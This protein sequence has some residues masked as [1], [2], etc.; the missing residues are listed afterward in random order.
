MIW[1]VFWE[2]DHYGMDSFQF[3]TSQKKKKQIQE[4]CKKET[5]EDIQLTSKGF[6]AANPIIPA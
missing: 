6:P 3:Y 5:T 4:N 1:L 2:I